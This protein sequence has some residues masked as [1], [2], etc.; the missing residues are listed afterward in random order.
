MIITTKDGALIAL[1][2][3]QLAILEQLN[4]TAKQLNQAPNIDF[5][6]MIR[7][8]FRS[9]KRVKSVYLYGGVGCG[10][11]TLMSYFLEKLHRPKKMVHYQ[12]FMQEMHLKLHNMQR[13]KFAH[14]AGKEIIAA[15]AKDIALSTQILCIDELEIKDITDA[16]LIMHLFGALMDAGVFIFVTTNTAPRDLYK[17]GIQRESF[18]PFID[19]VYQRFTVLDMH[20]APDYRYKLGLQQQE[21]ILFPINGQTM[22]KMANIALSLCPENVWTSSELDLF[23]RKLVFAKAY[24]NILYSNFTELFERELGYNDY[25]KITEHFRVILV[26]NIRHISEYENDIVTRFINFLDN[27]Y[28]NRVVL[29]MQLADAPEKLYVKGSR[30]SEFRR[31]LSRMREMNSSSYFSASGKVEY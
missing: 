30:Y 21:R 10:K 7:A 2:D 18:L 16:M 12:K 11:T 25:V 13:Q 5:R 6:A 24:H 17:D 19:E 23:G 29:F 22:G 9:P 1:D 26:L 31:A 27:C 4:A 28:Y 8:V 15:L 3:A 14:Q 20:N